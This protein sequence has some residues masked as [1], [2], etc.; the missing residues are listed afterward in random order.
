[1]TGSLSF[2]L[3]YIRFPDRFGLEAILGPVTAFILLVLFCLV[4]AI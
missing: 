2:I 4:L 1:M 3:D